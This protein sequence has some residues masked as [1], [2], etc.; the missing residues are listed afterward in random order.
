MSYFSIKLNLLKLKNASYVNLTSKSGKTKKCLVIPVDDSG[1]FV[2]KKG[3][4]LNL[5]AVELKERQEW[6]THF[7]KLYLD[8]EI[9]SKL[10]KEEQEQIPIFGG[11]KPVERENDQMAP[12][13]PENEFYK[14]DDSEP[15]F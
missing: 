3:I 5:T 15:V 10:T 1:L 8:K 6:Q 2:G 12:E 4:Y 11:M 9:Y 13:D 7:I 14:I